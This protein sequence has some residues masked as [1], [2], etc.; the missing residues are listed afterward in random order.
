MSNSE[1]KPFSYIPQRA[2]DPLEE[3]LARR[4]RGLPRGLPRWSPQASNVPAVWPPNSGEVGSVYFPSDPLYESAGQAVEQA[5][6]SPTLGFIASTVSPKTLANVLKPATGAAKKLYEGQDIYRAVRYPYEGAVDLRYRFPEHE[7]GTHV[8]IDPET[9]KF[10]HKQQGYDTDYILKMK[11]NV[12]SPIW[13]S[14]G[15][16]EVN[17]LAERLVR[18]NADKLPPEVAKKILKVGYDYSD[19]RLK[20]S[21][22]EQSEVLSEYAKKLQKVLK[23]SG[24]D[25]ISYINTVEGKPVE[26]AILFNRLDQTP[27]ELYSIR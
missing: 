18:E 7:F 10:V 9:A 5:T 17:F 27:S 2:T 16:W 1:F 23:D 12:K 26:S 11:S 20:R 13:V 24:F 14:D 22:G 4:A 25:H 8:T 19:E 15:A 3:L 6:G 21:W